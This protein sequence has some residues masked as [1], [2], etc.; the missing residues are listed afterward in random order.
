MDEAKRLLD[1]SRGL[2]EQGATVE[3]LASLKGALL[4]IDHQ[5]RAAQVSLMRQQDAVTEDLLWE[6][7]AIHSGNEA[8]YGQQLIDVK[9]Q[10]FGLPLVRKAR[11]PAAGLQYVSRL[12]VPLGIGL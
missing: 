8:L 5:P 1:I 10:R 11:Q 6:W 4:A 7:L 2:A 9:A 3:D 12:N